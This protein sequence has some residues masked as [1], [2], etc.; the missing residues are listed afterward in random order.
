MDTQTVKSNSSKK[1]MGTLV[2]LA[3]AGLFVVPRVLRENRQERGVSSD[4]TLTAVEDAKKKIGPEVFN[5]L[6]KAMLPPGYAALCQRKEGNK[7]EDLFAA[8]KAYNTRNESKMRAL[9]GTME[10]QGSLTASEKVAVDEFAYARVAG[11]VNNGVVSCESLAKRI[12]QGEW[13][14]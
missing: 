12:D 6:I 11:D 8:A 13:D 3:V 10:G 1:L 14:L 9:L 7:R 4:A 2:T 5:G